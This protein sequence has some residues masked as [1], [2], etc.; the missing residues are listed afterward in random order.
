M[1]HAYRSVGYGTHARLTHLVGGAIW[2]MFPGAGL[3]SAITHA[4]AM[5]FLGV[6]AF[7]TLWMWPVYTDLFRRTYEVRLRASG[8]VEFE[9]PLRTYRLGTHEVL[10]ITPAKWTV[11]D[12]HYL[13]VRHRGGKFWLAWPVDEFRDFA[14]RF[15]ELNP[16][17]EIETPPI[18]LSMEEPPGTTR[19]LLR[20]APLAAAF[21]LAFFGLFCFVALHHHVG[22]LGSIA[23]G[24]VVWF[25]LMF[26][27]ARGWV[28]FDD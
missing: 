3:I 18:D 13:V 10:S 4:D 26:G 25:A 19:A 12:Q 2:G 17:A 27:A 21:M 7:S 14:E 11:N 24:V 15:W 28:H 9:A 22:A 6:L 23:I 16:A 5:L 1:I 20:E 8:I